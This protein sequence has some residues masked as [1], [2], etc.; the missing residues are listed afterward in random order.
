MDEQTPKQVEGLEGP[1]ETMF[2]CAVLTV[3]AAAV[4]G[5]AAIIPL[6]VVLWRWAF[7]L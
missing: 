6:I 4:L 2:G 3:L 5:M 7:G 1:F